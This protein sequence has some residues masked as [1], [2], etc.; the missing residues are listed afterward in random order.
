MDIQKDELQIKIDEARSKLPE[1]TRQA[2]DAVDWKL[3]IIE[4]RESK[5]YSYTQLDDLEIETELLL[6][7]LLR[8]EDYPIELEK[9]MGLPKPE[10]TQLVNLMNE[11]IFQKVRQELI[12]RVAEREKNEKENTQKDVVAQKVEPVKEM[13]RPEENT[14]IE[15]MPEELPKG[16]E[17]ASLEAR[18]EI[19]AKIEKPETIKVPPI[20]SIPKKP[21]FLPSQKLSEPSKSLETKTEHSTPNLTPPAT[22][23]QNDKPIKPKTDPYREIPE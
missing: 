5:G 3:K 1:E 2:I 23:E 4:L 6:C 12:K 14:N 17:E 10:V 8:P 22:S 16:E 15:I 21:Q 18:D 7:G 19:L 11:K 9:R 20:I 13:E